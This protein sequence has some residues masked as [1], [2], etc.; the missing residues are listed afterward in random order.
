MNGTGGGAGG[1][2][3]VIASLA[4]RLPSGHV[5]AWARV[6]RSVTAEA[7]MSQ[8]RQ[9]EAQLI[10]AKP[11]FAL[12]GAAA[13]LVAAWRAANPVPSGEA[14]ALALEA[15]ALVQADAAARR[16]DVVVSG[17]ASS[18]VP[19]RLTSSVISGIIRDCHESLLV[20][21]FAAFGVA[22][23]VTELHRAA[24]RG[25]RIDLVLEGAEADGGTLRGAVGASAAFEGMGRDATFWTWPAKRRPVVGTSRAALHAKLIAA[26]ERVALLGSANLTD[27]ALAH[28]LELGVLIHDPD[29]VRRIVRHFQSLMKPGTG[30]LEPVA[31]GD[32]KTST[33]TGASDTGT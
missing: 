5:T 11:G 28:N 18:S 21:S 29:V 3:A 2:A 12:G 27:K 23:V 4:E 6:L 15:A 25:V 16:S 1:L 10:E 19:V 14:V 24:E 26:D 30:P 9:V 8:G 31:P 33:A 32:A 17:P 20:V 22:E 7:V 13:R